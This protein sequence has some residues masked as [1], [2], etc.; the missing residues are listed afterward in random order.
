MKAK[1]LGLLA[2]VFATLVQC[3]VANALS[4]TQ[5]AV[6][7]LG[8]PQVPTVTFDLVN[9]ST[10]FPPMVTNNTNSPKDTEQILT[11]QKFNTGL[12]NLTGVTITFTTAYDATA[13]VNVTQNSDSDDIVFFADATLGHSLSGG[14]I[15]TQSAPSQTFSASCEADLGQLCGSGNVTNNGTFNNL[16][17]VGFAAGVQVADFIGPGSF[18]LTATLSSALAPRIFPDN[19]TFADNSSFNGALDANWNGNVS[20]EYIYDPFATPV[21]EPLSLYLFATGLGGIA[22]LR[23][24]RR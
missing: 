20:V 12:G 18:N 13:S 21:P 6:I 23:R 24:R 15:M 7:N 17:G 3:A 1:S 14:L 5:T 9:D 4:I 2:G 22:L 11:F 16:G 19:E 10:E 8:A